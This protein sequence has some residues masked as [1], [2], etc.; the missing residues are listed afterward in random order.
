VFSKWGFP[1]ALPMLF[2][3]LKNVKTFL[4]KQGGI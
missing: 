3:W 2:A 1:R 4:V